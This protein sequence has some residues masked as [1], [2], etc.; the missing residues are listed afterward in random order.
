MRIYFLLTAVL[1]AVSLSF[2]LITCTVSKRSEDISPAEITDTTDVLNKEN[3]A[4]E[5][6]SVFNASSGKTSETDMS[7][8]IIGVVAGEMPASFSPEALKAQAVAAYTY[9]KYLRENGNSIIT[10]CP[11]LHQSYIDKDAQKKK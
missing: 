9:A 2:P 11:S 6:I 7:E 3:A 1:F 10:D 4:E 5:K 8:Y